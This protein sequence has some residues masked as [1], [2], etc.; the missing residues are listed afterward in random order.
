MDELDGWMGA[1]SRAAERERERERARDRSDAGEH[2]VS[3]C[4]GGGPCHTLQLQQQA[5]RK[6]ETEG[7][8]RHTAA[9]GAS[10]GR[11]EGGKEADVEMVAVGA[12][13]FVCLF[14]CLLACLLACLFTRLLACLWPSSLN[15]MYARAGSADASAN[16]R[17]GLSRVRQHVCASARERCMVCI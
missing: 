1:L 5:A 7:A 14:V 2:A 17:Q 3:T 8:N 13:M 16:D 12:W 11:K 15:C 4:P 10:R 9:A 6:E